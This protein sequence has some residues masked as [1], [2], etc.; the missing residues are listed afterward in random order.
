MAILPI[1]KVPEPVLRQKTKKV[2]KIDASIQKLID[3]MIETMYDA[4]GVGL[5]A[6]QVGV[7]LRI[8]V[9][10]ANDP[11]Q[12]SVQDSS[13]GLIVLINP[14]IVKRSGTRLCTEGCL[15]LPSYRSDE[16]PRS[17]KVVVKGQNR[18]GR[19]VRYTAGGLFAEAIE[20]EVDHLNGILYFDYLE[21]I[22]KLTAYGPP[23]DETG[24]EEEVAATGPS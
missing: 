17:E 21:S 7:S 24:E 16:V 13:P 15:S 6:T 1:V 2:K 9:I 14:E 10:H 18:D 22:D 12:R 19:P 4:P 5:A 8:C 11:D 23:E 20:H 3:D